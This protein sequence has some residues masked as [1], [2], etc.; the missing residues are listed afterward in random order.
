MS[1][2]PIIFHID[3]DAFFASIELIR[4]PHL[5]GKPL[6]IG[7]A[8]ADRGVVSTCSYEA[9]EYGVHSAMSMNEALRRCPKAVVLPVDHHHYL[10]VSREVMGILRN[11]CPYIQ[12]VSIDEAYLDMSKIAKYAEL[13]LPIA[14]AIKHS[15]KNLTALT[16]S[17]GIA[18]NKLVAKILS[19]THK[20]CGLKQVPQ[21]DEASFLAPLSVNV[22]PGIGK[23]TQERLKKEGYTQISHLQEAGM[24]T[25]VQTFGHMGY[26]YYQRAMGIDF[27]AVQWQD[28]LPKSI[29][30]ESTFNQDIDDIAQ[31]E[32]VIDQQIS[33]A[34]A[35]LHRHRMR[36]RGVSIKLRDSSFFTITRSKTFTL[37][38]NNENRIRRALKDLLYESYKEGKAVRLIGVTLENLTN[39]YW[40][41]TFWDDPYIS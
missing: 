37:H 20:P 12:V 2:E 10:G 4:H 23:K 31:L 21:G 33:Q 28:R 36:T 30:K 29:S 18:T 41:P 17:I 15:I 7:G 13:A 19:S 27:Q 35:K 24:D 39:G 3:M 38:T 40:Q 1:V 5:R 32:I 22:I 16:C 34:V 9:R 11:Y 25:L 14:K 6:I 26:S 8:P